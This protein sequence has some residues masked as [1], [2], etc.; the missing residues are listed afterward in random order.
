LWRAASPAPH[1]ATRTSSPPYA[2]R[3]RLCRG[4]QVLG[5]KEPAV[6]VG[7]LHGDLEAAVKIVDRYLGSYRLVF[8]GDCVDRGGFSLETVSYLLALK[9]LH[10]RRAFLLRGNHESM[11]VNQRCGFYYELAKNM[12][13]RAF[14]LLVRFNERAQR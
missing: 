2:P 8:L 1:R 5:V 11:L 14:E 3:R 9:L 4:P 13:Q 10:P 12:G 6:V 7:D